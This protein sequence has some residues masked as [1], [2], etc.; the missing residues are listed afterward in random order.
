MEKVRLIKA[1]ERAGFGFAICRGRLSEGVIISAEEW[2][3]IEG[4]AADYWGEFREN[5]PWIHPDLEAVAEDFG[6]YW[7]W[8]NPGAICFAE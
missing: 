5:S 1:I 3:D 7:E 2:N 8:E 6:G 4:Y